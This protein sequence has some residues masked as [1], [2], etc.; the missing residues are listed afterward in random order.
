MADFGLEG[1]VAV[2]TGASRGIG[3][4]IAHGLAQEGARV[5][6]A[7]RKQDALDTVAH[8]IG[9]AGGSALPVACHTGKA[10]DIE[11]L[12]ERTESE[13]GPA[14]ILINNAATNPYFGPLIDA[15][16]AA[17]DKTFEINTKGYFLMAQQAAKRMVPRKTG[18]IVN[19][20]SILGLSPEPLQGVYAMTKAAVV[21]MTK[22]LAVELGPSGVRC[23]CI[24]PGLIE[25][26]FAKVLIETPKLHQSYV[27]KTPLGRHGQP[28]ELVGAALY[29]AS[30]LSSYTTGA[31]LCCDGGYMA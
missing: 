13:F 8:A 14:D 19:V 30:P 10:A 31:V 20:A 12:F 26:Q 1:K 29:L 4:A 9:E 17:F 5:V 18:A 21:M 15:P 2:V 27:G 24:C 3:E 7:S 22:C 25:T 6:L 11:A 28:D 23:N 16:E